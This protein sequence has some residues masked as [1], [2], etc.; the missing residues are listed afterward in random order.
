MPFDPNLAYVL[1]VIGL[2]VAAT[3]AYIPGTGVIDLAAALSLVGALVLLGGVPT[4]P[5]GALLLGFDS[6]QFSALLFQL[7]PRITPLSPL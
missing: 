1:L 6:R 7:P 4:N 2:W 3:A 5:V